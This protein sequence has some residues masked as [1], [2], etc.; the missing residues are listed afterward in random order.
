[1]TP[2]VGSRGEHHCGA[3]EQ[4]IQAEGEQDQGDYGGH[5]NET[6]KGRLKQAVMAESI[7]DIG[8]GHLTADDHHG[9]G[10]IHIGQKRDG[11][12]HRCGRT[13]SGKQQHQADEHGDGARVD[14]Q[15]SWGWPFH[16]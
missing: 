11:C 3:I 14:Q 16:P 15:R 7:P 5:E 2:A 13:Q 8:T 12:I 6:D 1:M 9:Q 4:G 10:G